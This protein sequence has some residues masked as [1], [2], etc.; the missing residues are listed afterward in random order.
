MDRIQGFTSGYA[1][2]KYVVDAPEGGGKIPLFSSRIVSSEGREVRLRNYE[3]KDYTY[4]NP[5]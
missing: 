2:P 4:V 1:V 3:G 5:E